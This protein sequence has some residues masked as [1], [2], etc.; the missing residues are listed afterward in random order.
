MKNRVLPLALLLC[1][2]TSMFASSPPAQLKIATWN[3]EWFMKPETLRALTPTCL[4]ADAPRDG[5]RRAVPCNVVA[6]LARSHEDIA[7]L[8]RHARRLDADVI[9]LQEVDGE[10]AARLVFPGYQFCFSRRVALQNNGFAV[11]K[12]L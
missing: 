1:S 9:A 2:S 11:R 4:P 6:E 7:A 3:L 10:D 12:G 8:Q 5:A